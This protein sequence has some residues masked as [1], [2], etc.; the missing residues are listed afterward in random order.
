MKREELIHYFDTSMG[1]SEAAYALIGDGVA[2]LTEEF[3]PEEETKQWINQANGT[4]EVKSYTPSI[5]VEKEDCVDDDMQTC[6][7]KLVD[8]LPTGAAAE[9]YYVRFRLK[10][11]TEDGKY[12]AYRRKC[13]VSVTSTGG[14]AGSNVVNAIKIGGKGAAVKG[15]FDIKTKTFTEGEPGIGG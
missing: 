7:D 9:S 14:D 4:S 10:D 2:S 3:N 12:T 6:I 1:K 11:K 15:V 8:E 5:E 13:A